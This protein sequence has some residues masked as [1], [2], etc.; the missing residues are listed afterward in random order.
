VQPVIHRVELVHS[1]TVLSVAEAR[2]GRYEDAEAGLAEA[3]WIHAAAA[4]E[5][6]TQRDTQRL[7]DLE[8]EL[9]AVRNRIRISE[10]RRALAGRRAT[11]ELPSRPADAIN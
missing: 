7:A 10:G 8:C 6:A 9:T 11:L 4:Q 1:L 3:A 5:A 2:I